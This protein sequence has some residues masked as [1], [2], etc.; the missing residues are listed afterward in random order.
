[1][2]TRYHFSERYNLRYDPGYDIAYSLFSVERNERYQLNPL[3]FLVLKLLESTTLT[4]GQML[5]ILKSREVPFES[6]SIE[7]FL[8]QMTELGALVENPMS[9]E[10]SLPEIDVPHLNNDVPVSSSPCEAEL[11]F[12]KACNLRCLH[13]VY[14][15][16][17]SI[18]GEL[19]SAEWRR[20][21]DEF[22]ADRAQRIIF[23]GGEP[24]VYPWARELLHH[25][26]NRRIRVELL[27]NGTLI[28]SETAEILSGWNFSTSVSL[29]GFDAVTHNY[30]R[31]TDCFTQTITGLRN[32]S[33]TGGRFNISTTLHKK[34]FVQMSDLF[35]LA[36]ELGA[37]SIGF[38]I[39]D[40]LGRAGRHPELL[41]EEADI[42]CIKETVANLQTKTGPRI[43]FLD[44]P[45]VELD[46]R[47]LHRPDGER[48]Y[49]TAGTSRL[50]VRSD[51]AVFPCVYAFGDE[52]FRQGSLRD[53]RLSEI[54]AA[55]SW[56]LFRGGITLDQLTT[57]GQCGLRGNC[58]LKNCRLRAHYAH[59]DFYGKP[60][61]CSMDITDQGGADFGETPIR[62]APNTK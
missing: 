39:I 29:D 15:S 56:K 28:D 2:F 4:L 47:L 20:I 9:S 54:W 12:T 58:A 3:S 18:P 41:L 59:G 44:I 51:G 24:L 40:P 5:D 31:G 43:E 60:P 35:L 26:R 48:I 7:L 61:R 55:S 33:R 42:A 34:N 19:S 1:M 52:A 37:V 62:V 13:C 23:S 46:R 6:P 25:L 38:I 16:K 32:L 10:P 14:D 50:A 57:C 36:G 49:C 11:H 8:G 45:S 17:N 30:L 53:Q 21:L 27:T 22:I